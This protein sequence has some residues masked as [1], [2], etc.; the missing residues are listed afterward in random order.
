MASLRLQPGR[1]DDA[2]DDER[3]HHRHGRQFH[4]Q[5]SAP[6]EVEVGERCAFSPATDHLTARSGHHKRESA[7]IAGPPRS[8]TK[9]TSQLEMDIYGGKTAYNNLCHVLPTA[10]S[11]VRGAPSE[12]AIRLERRCGLDYVWS[13]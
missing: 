5:P 8:G 1:H 6:A 9:C 3:G 2:G 7:A 13:S 10:R 12:P 4:A 11:S